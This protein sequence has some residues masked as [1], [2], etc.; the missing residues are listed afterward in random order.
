MPTVLVP[1]TM[2]AV[3]ATRRV[4]LIP[5]ATRPI[6][7]VVEYHVDASANDCPILVPTLDWKCEKDDPERVI[8]VDPV[9]GWLALVTEL[10]IPMRE[11]KEKTSLHVL[12]RLPV[13]MTILRVLVTA[14][15]TSERIAESDIHLVVSLAVC[16]TEKTPEC[17][18]KPNPQPFTVILCDPVEAVFA[19]RELLTRDLSTEYANVIEF[20]SSPMVSIV[21]L[22]AET[23]AAILTRTEV[24]D[25]QS[26]ASQAEK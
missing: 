15:V 11:S 9:L 14:D 17:S 18:R 25:R 19:Q 16:P 23:A 5:C 4:P 22:D 10:C 7:P 20:A 12:A 3:T 1:G 6:M 2:P 24:S 26:V 8:E 13:V 21:V